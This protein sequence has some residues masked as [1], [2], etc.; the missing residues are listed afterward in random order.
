MSTITVRLNK[1]E[2]R[3]FNEYAKL[4]GIPLSTL[5]KNALEEKIEDEIDM[6]AILEYE[7]GIKN[8]SAQVYDHDE[9]KKILGL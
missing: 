4:Y 5:F 7:E 8:N 3:A 1:D 9:V 2:E 6:R